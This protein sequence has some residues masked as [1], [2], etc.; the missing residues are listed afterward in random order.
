MRILILAAA[1]LL[2]L[3]ACQPETKPA[4]ESAAV[5]PTPEEMGQ[6]DPD[7]PFTPAEVGPPRTYEAFSKT[8]MSFTPGVLTLTPTKQQSPNLP[9]GAVFAFGNG[10]ILETTEMPGGA[11]MGAAPF[12]FKPFIIDT[13]GAPIDV[14]KI[15]MHSVD[16]ETVPAGTANGGFCDKTSF[17][18]TYV[19]RSPGAEDL[20]IIPFSGDT[21]PPKDASV[22]CGTFGYASVH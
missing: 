22:L 10:Y 11:E 13:T 19:V 21:W 5:A 14:S 20:T 12:D 4:E 9:P 3:A 1:S 18:A 8:A 17:L 7:A 16:K 2:T 15:Q 6:D